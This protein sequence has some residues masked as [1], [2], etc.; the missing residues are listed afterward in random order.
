MTIIR[1]IRRRLRPARLALRNLRQE[2]LFRVKR[3]LSPPKLPRNEGGEVLIHLGCGFKNDPRYINVDAS[4]MP[5]VHYVSH[6]NKLPMF[7]KNFA[8]LIYACHMLEHI[9]H[10]KIVSVLIEWRRV[11]KPGGVL[12]IAVPDFEKMVNLYL[13]NKQGMALIQSPLMGAQ[14]CEHGYHRTAFDK[15]Y[16][17]DLFIQ[18]GFKQVQEWDT[19]TAQ[20]YSF[21]DWAGGKLLHDKYA[22]SLNLEAVK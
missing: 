1:N 19:K 6:A 8:D 18:A 22:I 9:D 7:K 12:R 5:H 20:Y 10:P 17:S 14:D 15:D 3:H 21:N 2:L 16:L 4:P 13:E 11:L